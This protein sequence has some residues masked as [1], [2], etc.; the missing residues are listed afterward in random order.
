M[1]KAFIEPVFTNNVSLS[2]S[3]FKLCCI[4]L[5]RHDCNSCLFLVFAS[6]F[7]FKVYY[8]VHKQKFV[9]SQFKFSVVQPS[10]FFI[11]CKLNYTEQVI[12]FC[13]A[14]MLLFFIRNPVVW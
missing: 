8:V 3:A 1:D 13:T 9:L 4:Y 6:N 11:P 10:S 2:I 12:L 5:V 14:C 7:L